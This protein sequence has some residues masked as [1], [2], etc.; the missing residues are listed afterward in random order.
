[1]R[2]IFSGMDGA[3]KST[4]I[5]RLRDLHPSKQSGCGA[6]WLTQSSSCQRTLQKSGFVGFR[7]D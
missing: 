4:Q 5:R 1:M 3:G 2:I 6:R 7:V